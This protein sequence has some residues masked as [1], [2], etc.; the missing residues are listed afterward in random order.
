[1]ALLVNAVIAPVDPTELATSRF[2]VTLLG[3][4][5]AVAVAWAAP[6][7]AWLRHVNRA[8]AE[9]RELSADE[10]PRPRELQ[11]AL[12]ELHEAYDTASGEARGAE[13]PTEDLLEVSHRAYRI[14]DTAAERARSRDLPDG[15]QH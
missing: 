10:P 5:V 11:R 4:G 2:W 15:P 1:M 12:V 8:L 9:V 6:R 3:A 7:G 13:L 14:L